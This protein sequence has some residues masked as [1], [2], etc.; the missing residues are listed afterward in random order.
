[1]DLIKYL[2]ISLKKYVHIL[3]YFNINNLHVIFS[4]S[5]LMSC[6]II[7]I[8][9]SNNITQNWVL[10]INLKNII[11]FWNELVWGALVSSL[12]K[13]RLFTRVK[14]LEISIKNLRKR[15]FQRLRWL[16]KGVDRNTVEKDV[17]TAYTKVEESILSLSRVKHC[18]KRCFD[19]LHKGRR[20]YFIFIEGHNPR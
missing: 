10:Y 15:L 9:Y 5:F 20:K 12:Q 2:S 1:M 6:N 17:S 18:R 19:G 4:S 13:K 8:N 16:S 3:N 11:I 7:E 14:T